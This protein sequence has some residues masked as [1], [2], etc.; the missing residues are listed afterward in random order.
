M[1]FASIADALMAADRLLQ[2]KGYSRATRK[3]YL[4]SLR[5][6]FGMYPDIN[7]IIPGQISSFLLSRRNNGTSSA[8]TNLNLQAIQFYVR[9]ILCVSF[10]AQIPFAKKPKRLPVVLTHEEILRILDSIHNLKHKVLI[11][12]AYASGLRVSEVVSLKVSDIDIDSRTIHIKQAKGLKDRI[13]VFSEKLKD[14]IK[15]FLVGKSGADLLFQSQRGGK[16]SERTAQKIFETAVRNAHIVKPV[17][18]HS[19]RHSF[20]THLLE[21][22][23]DVRYVQ[24]LLGHQNIRTTQGYTHVTNPALKNISSPL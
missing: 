5:M 7:C 15:A 17:T 13:S 20:A 22:G 11:A 9:N 2:L 1:S 16:L 19:L 6:Y 3:S 21:N 18:F 24:V 8:T 23:V 4:Y 12:L 14:S 10:S